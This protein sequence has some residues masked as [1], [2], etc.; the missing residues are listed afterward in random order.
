[1]CIYN[2]YFKARDLFKRSN[3]VE[4]LS[5]L[6]DDQLKLM[7]NRTQ[8]Q[9]GLCAFRKGFYEDCLLYLNFFCQ[10]GTTKLKEFLAQNYNKDNEKNI[11][12]DKDDKRRM[13]PCIMT[14]NIDEI[15][16]SY[17]IASM[18]LELPNIIL[19]KLGKIKKAI[20]SNFKK[21]LDS[22]EKQIFNGPPESNKELILNSASFMIKGDWEKCCE[23]ICNMKIYNSYK[24]Q[25]EIK[26]L[27][28]E[29]IKESSLKCYLFFYTEQ[30]SNISMEAIKTKF[31]L[32]EQS[33]KR[34]INKMIIENGFNS[35]W[36]D[37]ILNVYHYSNIINGATSRLLEN[38]TTIT[39]L[40]INL[41]DLS[42]KLNHHN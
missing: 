2:K 14:I 37:N 19:L 12:F 15:E 30:F 11:F 5:I 18:I 35:K 4:I 3:L 32:D 25:N 29:R 34:I 10:T 1:L 6:K 27:I 20:S 23:M 17:L 28:S 38:V 16:C 9:L 26:G 7:Y 36:N 40:N 21:Y 22:Y 31:K 42:S 33:I 13:T 41:M 39:D 8:V 24:N